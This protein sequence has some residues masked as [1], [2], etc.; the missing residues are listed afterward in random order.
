V[1]CPRS[2]AICVPCS[3]AD[4]RRVCCC[5]FLLQLSFQ[6]RSEIRI[7]LLICVNCR[8]CISVGVH[9]FLLPYV[10][11]NAGRYIFLFVKCPTA[12]GGH[13]MLN[14]CMCFMSYVL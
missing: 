8:S 3:T 6:M 14:D 7:V 5:E 1:L 9:I 2:G 11:V 4:C 12:V 13:M 10:G